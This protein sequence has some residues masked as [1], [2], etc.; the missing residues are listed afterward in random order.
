MLKVKNMPITLY[1]EWEG[2][3]FEIDLTPVTHTKRS[4]MMRTGKQGDVAFWN[5]YYIGFMVHL[6]KVCSEGKEYR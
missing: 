4:K 3:H 1:K 6:F 5:I 2:W